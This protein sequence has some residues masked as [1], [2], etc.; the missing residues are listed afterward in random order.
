MASEKKRLDALLVERGLV[1]S[2]AKAQALI[3]AGAVFSGERR[4][5]KAGDQR[6]RR[7]AA[8]G[9]RAGHPWVS[10]GGLKLAHALEHF[11]HRC[12]RARRARCRRLDRRLHRRAAGARRGAGLCRRCRPWPAR[13]EAAPGSARRR[14]GAHQ[15][16]PS[17]GRADARSRSISSSAMPAS[18]VSR[19]CCRRRWRWREP[20]ARLVALIKPQFEVGPGRVGKGGVVRDPALHR[21]GLRAHRR[22]ARRAAG[23]AVLGIVESPI[24]GPEGNIEFLVY[25]HRR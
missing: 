1:E 7:P 15:R 9:A 5:D 22:L 4:L 19:P 6:R 25:A 24:R 18:S 13:L 17:D 10:R 12:R 11:A 21:R 23:W 3:L 2:R 8:R 14:A 16:A 20:G